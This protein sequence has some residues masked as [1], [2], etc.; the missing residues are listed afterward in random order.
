MKKTYVLF[1]EDQIKQFTLK[2]FTEGKT[3]V[4]SYASRFDK[5]IC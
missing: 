1:Q 2:M 5:S 4:S 3:L